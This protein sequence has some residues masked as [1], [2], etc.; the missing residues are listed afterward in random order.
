[1]LHPTPSL[2]LPESVSN[3]STPRQPHRQPEDFPV[4]MTRREASTYLK[5]VHGLNRHEPNTLAKM[6]VQGRGPLFQKS[7][8]W[9][10]Y[11]RG[12]LDLYAAERLSQAHRSTAEHATARTA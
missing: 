9:V 3:T 1:M 11:G 12:H 7:G 10:L 4:R 8:R 6:A 5:E 2:A